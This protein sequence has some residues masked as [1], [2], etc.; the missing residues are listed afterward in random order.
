MNW[1]NRVN[2]QKSSHVMI[3]KRYPNRKLYDTEARHYIALEDIVNSLQEGK[4][5]RVVDY[6]TGED[7]T[8]QVLSQA[9]AG[10]EKKQSGF[11]P[12]PVLAGLIQAG[13]TTLE[14]MRRAML[15]PLDLFRHVDEEIQR[16]IEILIQQGVL[17]EAEGMQ[18]VEKL[19]S[20]SPRKLTDTLFEQEIGRIVAEQGVPTRD[21]FQ[22]LVEQVDEIA[23][24]LDSLP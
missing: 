5:V 11:I 4:E 3:V 16:R 18:W 8:A 1:Q 6:A 15:L 13:G 20:V 23:H 12:R 14:V 21:E 17:T 10:R 24:K 19:L 7:L 9:I 22:H 2:D